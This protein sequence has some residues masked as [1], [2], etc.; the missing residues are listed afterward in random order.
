MGPFLRKKCNSS[1]KA[2][3]MT[4]IIVGTVSLFALFKSYFAS[5]L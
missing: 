2:H 5:L 4:H 1:S 3:I